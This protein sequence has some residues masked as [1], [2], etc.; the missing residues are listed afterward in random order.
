VAQRCRDEKITGIIGQ[1]LNI[2]V[3]CHPKHFPTLKYRYISYTKNKDAPIVSATR[4]NWFWEKYLPNAEPHPYASP[5]LATSLEGLPPA[6][7]FDSILI[8]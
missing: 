8:N 4:M 2:P 5:L 6:R 7:K 1:V 3:T